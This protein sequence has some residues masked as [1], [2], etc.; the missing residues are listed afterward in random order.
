MLL[1][2]AANSGRSVSLNPGAA[3][4]AAS[5]ILAFVAAYSGYRWPGWWEGP[6]A[7]LARNPV[8]AVLLTIIAPL[9]LRALLL[10]LFP[11]REPRVQD[12]FSFLLAADTFAHGRLVNPSHP[13][14]VHFESEHI[15]VK[16]V[17]VS[18]FPIAQAAVLAVGKLLF[19]HPWAGV[20]LSTGLMCGAI[21]WMLQGWLPPRWALLGALL[22]ILR[23]GVSSY[24]MNSYWG[25]CV[26]AIGG[27][28]VLGAL[29]RIMSRP[30]WRYA[31][32]MGV[33]LM[34]LANSR[35]FEGA[36]FG[37]IVAVPL[38]AWLCG[39][40]GPPRAVAIR[41]VAL[42]LLIILAFTA[43]TMGYYFSR[44]SG[45]LWVPPYVLY[46]STMT[47]APHF[48][49]Q[50]PRPEPLY[51]N[52]ELRHFY[53][54]MEMHDYQSARESP[55]D[56]L[57][58]KL[59]TYWRFYVGPILLLP[60]LTARWLWRDRK[61]RQLILMAAAFTL[62]LVGQVWHNAH[63]AAPAT[64]L[65]ILIV[66]LGMRQLRLWQ[67]RGRPVGLSLVRLLPLACA[68]MLL[69]QIVAR[70]LPETAP[71]QSGWRWAR[72]GGI[73]RA[74]ILKH[75]VE[76]GAQHLIFVRYDPSHDT[77][78]DWVYNDADID[79]ARVVWA[80]DLD[81]GS[82]EE[83]MRHF[84]GRSVWLVEPDDPEPHLIAYRD[85]PPRPMRF[86]QI[87]APGIATLRSGRVRQKV[88]ERAPANQPYS[89]DEWNYF[90][91][92][93]TGVEAP[94]MGPQCYTGADRT[95]PVSFE[96]WFS[97]LQQQR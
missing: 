81:R 86:V 16:P 51:N 23:L 13:F 92:D 32:A 45:K 90:F 49:W 52:R 78:D 30:D 65:V 94:T 87:G 48:L 84:T 3:L 93:V 14:W 46:R 57:W 44:V 82:N 50:R 61:S 35:T 4:A 28:L 89:C 62:A 17:Y 5:V 70:Q 97:W 37:V 39:K 38:L 18:A 69:V 24:W 47:M 79:A 12:E 27:A 56:D 21:C 10:P 60:L 58:E 34:I 80:R 1:A 88:L 95:H 6:L 2:F 75:L 8:R 73:V 63:Y 9:V 25:G 55:W 29:P 40:N 53:V 77:G 54:D 42:P 85:A 11:I 83:L 15:L 74:N 68:A 43:V 31:A 66:V 26:A 71:E 22:V 64:G 96:Q 59:G 41:H 20:W 19:G 72:P 36:V 33:G 91:T 67:W 7:R 76:S